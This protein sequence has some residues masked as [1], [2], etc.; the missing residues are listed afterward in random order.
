MRQTDMMD[1]PFPVPTADSAG[2]WINTATG[3]LAI[4]QCKDCQAYQFPP[5]ET[6]RLC[7]GTLQWTPISG[8]GRVYTFIVQ[9]HVISPVFASHC[10]YAIALVAPDEAPHVRIP[11]RVEGDPAHVK[12][13]DRVQA[14][15]TASGDGE[16][17]FPVFDHEENA[18]DSHQPI[19]DDK[20]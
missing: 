5:L 6:C 4:Q 15:I 7:N 1:L 13:G 12:I 10:P 18:K 20:I 11:G 9:E 3:R 17:C 2:F 16:R 14:L 19:L 8:R